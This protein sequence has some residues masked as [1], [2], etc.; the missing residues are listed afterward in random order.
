MIYTNLLE[1]QLKKAIQTK[2]QINSNKQENN[3]Y[4]KIINKAKE[5]SNTTNI[6]YDVCKIVLFENERL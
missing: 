4:Y 3:E 5:I 6:S 1:H 2:I